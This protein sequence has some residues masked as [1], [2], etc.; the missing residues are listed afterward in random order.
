MFWKWFLIVSPCKIFVC[1]IL[2]YHSEV[3]PQGFQ[4]SEI[5]GHPTLHLHACKLYYLGNSKLGLGRKARVKVKVLHTPLSPA[6]YWGGMRKQRRR[7][8]RRHRAA[9]IVIVWSS[10]SIG[11]VG[12]YWGRLDTFLFHSIAVAVVEGEW[13]KWQKWAKCMRKFLWANDVDFKSVLAFRFGAESR[14]ICIITRLR[15][16][17]RWQLDRGR[18][19]IALRFSRHL[20]TYRECPSDCSFYNHR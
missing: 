9:I 13:H 20:F 3:E 4:Q 15:I 11:A 10:L 2:S 8:R 12:D 5:L 14:W 7:T 17:G 18:L 19:L 6:R 1:N 16:W